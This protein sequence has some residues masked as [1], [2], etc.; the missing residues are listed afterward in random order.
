MLWLS[1]ENYLEI[2][3]IKAQAVNPSGKYSKYTYAFI[4]HECF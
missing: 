3:P 4:P 2:L 1:L